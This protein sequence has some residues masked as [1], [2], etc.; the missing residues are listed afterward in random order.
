MRGWPASRLSALVVA[1]AGFAL[2][3]AAT[4]PAQ[5]SSAA[6]AGPLTLSTAALATPSPPTA[7]VWRCGT[8]GSVTTLV[9]W[10]EDGTPTGAQVGVLRAFAAGGPWTPVATG[11][12]PDGAAFD[13]V[14]SS[15]GSVY[16]AVQVDAG[17]WQS[18]LSP[19]ARVLLSCRG[20]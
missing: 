14:Q 10:D 2:V 7:A 18:P 9:L 17:G 13:I 5:F 16:Y 8:R 3:A 12:P 15:S 1:A 6:S 19:P 11:Q 20:D 4:A